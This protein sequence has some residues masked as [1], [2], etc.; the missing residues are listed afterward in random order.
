MNIIRNITFLFLVI[1]G[2]TITAKAQGLDTAKLDKYFQV[3]NENNKFM[4]SVSIFRDGNEIYS[5]SVGFSDIDKQISNSE[6]SKYCIGSI[7]KMITSVMVFQAI[8][9]GEL[10]LSQTIYKYFPSLPNAEKIT[11]ADLLSHRS[12]IHNFTDIGNFT[13]WPAKTK[14]QMIDII[15]AGGSD[16][17]PDTHADYSNSNYVLLSYILETIYRK[18]YSDILAA[19]IVRPL[20]LHNTYFGKSIININNNESNSYKYSDKWQLQSVT[21]P[22]VTLGAGCIISNAHDLNIFADAL[23]NGKL[24]TANSL[25]AM[26]NIRDGIGLG[27]F[28][29]P[30]FSRQGYGH[31]GGVDGFN[32]MLIYMPDDKISYAITSNGLN[33]NFTEIH[34]AVLNSIYGKPFDIPKFSTPT[35]RMAIPTEY[36]G[37]YKS[38]QYPLAVIIISNGN[39]LS[40]QEEGQSAIQLEA[41]SEHVF[42][43]VE[44]DLV[45]VFNPANS[46]MIL[47]QGEGVFYFKKE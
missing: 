12:G 31:R 45:T 30:Y 9:A 11:I 5:K 28:D 15:T 20:S 1:I 16:F 19:K 14:T 26:Q 23:F 29:V 8:E 3:L 38:S 42:R 21:N 24:I 27:L 7:S 32:S 33:Y 40:I 35:A 10:S 41:D 4:G 18:S 17:E 37:R 6:L 2:C 43:F 46:T 36:A 34:I 44:N 13:K 25:S 22:T 47:I 39:A